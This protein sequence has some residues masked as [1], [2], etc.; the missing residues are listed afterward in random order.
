MCSDE[1]TVAL[2]TLPAMLS[3]FLPDNSLLPEH[4]GLA[5][6]QV[7]SGMPVDD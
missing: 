4:N 5:L 7:R 1:N 6:A 3:V 2:D